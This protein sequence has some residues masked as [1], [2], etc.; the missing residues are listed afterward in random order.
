MDNIKDYNNYK[1]LFR[2]KKSKS[3]IYVDFITDDAE[4]WFIRVV[5]Y[6]SKSGKINDTYTIIKKDLENHLNFYK[7][8]GFNKI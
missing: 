3:P 6:L 4:E 2:L 5:T 1:F 7:N 8:K